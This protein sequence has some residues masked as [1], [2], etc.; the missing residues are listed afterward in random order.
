MYN[1]W[2]AKKAGETSPYVGQKTTMHILYPPKAGS[3]QIAGKHLTD[4]GEKFL[5]RL[6]KKHGPKIMKTWPDIP[7]GVLEQAAFK[8][9]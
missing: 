6:Y 8:W 5:E 1:V 4:V 7:D 3:K 2:E 9:P